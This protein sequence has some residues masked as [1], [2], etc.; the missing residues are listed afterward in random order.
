[1]REPERVTL[2]A[3]KRQNATTVTKLSLKLAQNEQKRSKSRK[4]K[5]A[6]S[7]GWQRDLV[8]FSAR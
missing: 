3:R 4:Q 5:F 6:L 1:M 8:R 2:N 7:D